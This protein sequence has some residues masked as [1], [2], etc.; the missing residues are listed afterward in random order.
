MLVGFYAA[1]F[2][3]IIP[4]MTSSLFLIRVKTDMSESIDK[5][6]I[7][8][9]IRE[10]YA[11][12][13]CSPGEHFSYETGRKGARKLGYDPAWLNQ[14]PDEI[15]RFYCG[16][17]NPFEPGPLNEGQRVLDI[18]CGAGVDCLIAGSMVG[19]EGQVCGVD[20][21]PEMVRKARQHTEMME[22]EHVEI[23]QG[24]VED[25]SLET[26]RFDI[27]ISNGV[28]NLIPDKTSAFAEANRVLKSGSRLQ[29][30]DIVLEEGSSR[31]IPA[32]PE[33]WAG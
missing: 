13:A 26:D 16:V 30:A 22:L 5:N 27:V 2:A 21:S 17:S 14:I 12:V 7:H 10:Q 28:F 4:L 32:T 1:E 3:D 8:D 6:A 15:M 23:H 31:D 29:F 9:A 11:D 33:D 25:L 19:S 24:D 18:G 20:L